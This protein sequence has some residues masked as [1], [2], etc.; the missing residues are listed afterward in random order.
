[1]GRILTLG[2]LEGGLGG[3]LDQGGQQ[4]ALFDWADGDR[5]FFDFIPN[6]PAILDFFTEKTPEIYGG[7]INFGNYLFWDKLIIAPWK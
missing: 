2:V 5:T 3:A 7:L 1:M 4:Q 6:S